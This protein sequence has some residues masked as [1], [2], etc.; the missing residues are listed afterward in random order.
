MQEHEAAKCIG[1]MVI[2]SDEFWGTYTGILF[3]IKHT[4]VG[5]IAIIKICDNI[6]KPCQHA[7]F[8]PHN[9]YDRLP[10]PKDS[11]RFFKLENI[12]RNELYEC[13]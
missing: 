2:A 10:Y 8:F 13:Y 1:S 4:R 5:L 6:V 11:I 12:E 3:E 7:I 9:M